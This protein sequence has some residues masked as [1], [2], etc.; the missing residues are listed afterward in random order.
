[1]LAYVY[2]YDDAGVYSRC[3]YSITA[4]FESCLFTVFIYRLTVLCQVC[5]QIFSVFQNSACSNLLLISRI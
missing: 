5:F 2:Q 4:N 3:H 1:M